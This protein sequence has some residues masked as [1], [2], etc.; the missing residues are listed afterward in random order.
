VP[1]PDHAAVGHFRP[2]GRR[3]HTLEGRRLGPSRAGGRQARSRLLAVLHHAS[4]VVPLQTA[5]FAAFVPIV[6]IAVLHQHAMRD[7]LFARC[8]EALSI[9]RLDDSRAPDERAEHKRSGRAVRCFLM[10]SMANL[11]VLVTR[12]YDRGRIL[13]IEQSRMLS[14]CNS[15]NRSVVAMHG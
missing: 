4:L 8:V 10:V 7:G 12:I 13:I 9:R 6:R 5:A 11:S 3:P 14:S 1:A 2:S 15:N